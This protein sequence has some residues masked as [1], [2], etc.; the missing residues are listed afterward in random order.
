MST[1]LR[2]RSAPELIDAVVSVL[3]QHYLELLT[4]AVLYVVLVIIG[5]A[6]PLIVIQLVAVPLVGNT[7]SSVLLAIIWV[8]GFVG[9][10]AMNEATTT[11]IVA[12]AYL[13]RPVSVAMAVRHAWR[14]FWPA[15]ILTGLRFGSMA[16][17]M[18]LL[19]IPGVLAAGWFFA[20]ISV[21]MIEGAGPI[22]SLRR[23][24]ELVRGSFGRV[25]GVLVLCAIIVAIVRLT[26]VLTLVL[27]VPGLHAATPTVDAISGCVG[28]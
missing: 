11:A 21:L 18:L 26:V 24:R 1:A 17:G 10:I 2:P 13:G 28:F 6:L 8:T 22:A 12:G 14:R 25:A 15:T 16:V 27:L 5:L 9:A 23:S 19:V 7:V 4:V 20:G 3:R